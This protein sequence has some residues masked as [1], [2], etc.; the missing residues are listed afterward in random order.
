MAKGY[1][2][3]MTRRGAVLAVA[4]VTVVIA[5]CSSSDDAAPTTSP[6]PST[7]A[8]TTEPDPTT[9]AAPTTTEAPTTTLDPAEAL[10][11]E[12]EADLRAGLDAARTAGVD[13]FD[14]AAE[15]EAIRLRTGF[16]RENLETRLADWRVKNYAIRQNQHV[17][18]SVTIETPARLLEDGADVAEVQICEVDS[19]I[20]VEPGAGANGTDAV[21]GP[22]VLTYRTRV[23]LRRIDGTWKI[24]GADELGRWE[25]STSCDAAS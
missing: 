15:D 17:P 4:A 3:A 11:A 14:Q 5:A 10:A 22:D 23:L 1:H 19:W 20:L 12:V 16:A 24:E 8:T 25:G 21:V 13:P 6:A 9:T 18:P 2:F 7:V